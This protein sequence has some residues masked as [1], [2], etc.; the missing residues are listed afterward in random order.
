MYNVFSGAFECVRP[1]DR[2]CPSVRQ[3]LSVRPTDVR[4]SDRFARGFAMGFLYLPPPKGEGK[5]PEGGPFA[6]EYK[7]HFLAI[8]KK[9]GKKFNPQKRE[10]TLQTF[11]GDYRDFTGAYPELVQGLKV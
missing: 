3:I 4:P 10:P 7:Y 6:S 5:A 9:N 2:L 11:T 1:S 8:I